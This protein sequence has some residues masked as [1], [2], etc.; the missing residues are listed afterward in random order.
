VSLF[1]SL[2]RGRTDVFPI[3]WENSKGKSGYSPACAN[4]WKVVICQKPR[5]KCSDCPNQAFL[6][7]TDAVAFDHLAGRKTIGI[8]PL[9]KDET[10]WFLAI[11]FDKEN[12][13]EDVKAF[14]ATC[15]DLN[16]PVAIEVSRSGNG[17]HAWIFFEQRVPARLARELGSSLITR[18]CARIHQLSLT[19][20]DR[21][22]PNQDTLPKGGFGNL[23]A[24]PL[25]K[26][27]REYGFSAFV[28][29]RLQSFPDQWAYLA[30]V[31]RMAPAQIERTVATARNADG[32]LGLSMPVTD[33]IDDDPWTLPPSGRR[34]DSPLAGPFPARVRIVSS[35]LLYI[36]KAGLPPPLLNRIIRL[37]AFQNPEFY[38]AQAMRFP[39]FDKP[40]VI[41]CAEIFPRHVGLP[42]GCWPDL[43]QL[44]TEQGI[45]IELT[46]ER[47]AGKS[48]DAK[49]VGKLTTNQALARSKIVEHE[50]GILVA[51]TGFG[52]TVTAA[53]VIA[54]RKVNS[55]IL[56][57]RRQLV[58]QWREQLSAFLTFPSK[59]IGTIGGGARRPTGLVDIAVLQSLNRG[60]TVDDLVADY[61]QIVVDECHHIS[62]FSFEQV[63]KAAKARYILGLTATPIRRDG[64][65]PIIVMQCGPIRYRPTTS[66][67]DSHLRHWVLPR[68]TA[69]KINGE[70]T[71]IQEVYKRLVEDGA[72]NDTIVEDVR[73]AIAEGRRPLVLTERTDHVESLA[74]RFKDVAEHVIVFHGRLGHRRRQDRLEAMRQV[75]NRGNWVI[76]STGRLIGEGFDHAP[77][78]TLFLALPI[79]WRGTLQQYAGRLHRKYEGKSDVR[80][81]DYVDH[82][83]P[84]LAKMYA[85]RLR[86]YRA[87][88]YALRDPIAGAGSELE[89]VEPV[90]T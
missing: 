65:H 20:Y 74:A 17:A 88:G 29:E 85:R 89:C 5:I 12:W 2:F 44:I 90:S 21:F 26:K 41:G 34:N 30:S 70:T 4:E 76:I 9:L 63:L 71:G 49:F 14:R 54:R 46:D 59:A 48:L 66:E 18:T 60:G 81:Y 77:L 19:S 52:K 64:H 72:R 40:R 69:V 58:D 78:D 8:Y 38:K 79:S 1:L 82:A 87:M 23:I 56:V 75:A 22:F 33:E 37:A 27:P 15:N 83:V 51:P 31:Q 7:L 35:N 25:Q 36:D 50:T 28:D 43:E 67:G 32:V 13:K 86:G 80:I 68:Q 6:P 39:T 57:H 55:L 45:K 53:S 11:D 62:A 10:C 61:G 73:Q 47:S 3:R 42:R 16:V 24:L 84:V